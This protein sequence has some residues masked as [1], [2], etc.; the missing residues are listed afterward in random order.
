MPLHR[1]SERAR[2]HAL[3]GAVKNSA[4][5]NHSPIGQSASAGKP[6]GHIKWLAGALVSYV[7]QSL[8]RKR[9][10]IGMLCPACDKPVPE[11]RG[12]RERIWCS[13]QHRMFGAMLRALPDVSPQRLARIRIGSGT[14]LRPAI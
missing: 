13:P 11:S 1:R 8:D 12:N 5:S 14:P 3:S 7:R 10:V 2:L 4:V 9:E 6:L